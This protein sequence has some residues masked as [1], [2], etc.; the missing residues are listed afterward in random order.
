ME[1]SEA[2]LLEAN[3]KSAS[4]AALASVLQNMQHLHPTAASMQEEQETGN[5]QQ[6]QQQQQQQSNARQVDPRVLRADRLRTAGGGNEATRTKAGGSHSHRSDSELMPSSSEAASTEKSSA[7]RH[8]SAENVGSTNKWT[9]VC[10]G[11]ACDL[12]R[13]QAVFFSCKLTREC[14]VDAAEVIQL[15]IIAAASAASAAIEFRFS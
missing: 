12:G 4:A 14:A 1:D 2:Q 15:E 11:V 9:Q 5:Q 10:E 7:L 8:I 13:L 3:E 6:Q